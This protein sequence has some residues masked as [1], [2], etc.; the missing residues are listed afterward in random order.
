MRRAEEQGHARDASACGVALPSVPVVRPLGVV[1]E[2]AAVSVEE[3]EAPRLEER[4]RSRT[5]NYHFI[6]S[7]QP[8]P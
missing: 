1:V 8:A 4:S 3:G 2:A 7:S 5:S 6:M